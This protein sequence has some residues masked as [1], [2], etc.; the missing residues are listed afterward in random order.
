MKTKKTKR[1]LKKIMYFPKKLSAKRRGD[2][3]KGLMQKYNIK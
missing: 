3:E 1:E 2:V